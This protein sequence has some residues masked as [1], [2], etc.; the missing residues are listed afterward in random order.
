MEHT[1]WIKQGAD[2]AFPDIVWSRPESRV[3]AGKLL[4]VGGNTHAFSAPAQAF[5]ESEA[6]GVGVVNVLLP[7]SLRK[8]VGSFI[9]EAEYAPHTPSGSFAREALE[10]MLRLSTCSDGVLLAGDVGRNSETAML[11][12]AFT[13][14]YQGLLTVTHDVADYFRELPLMVVDRPNTLLVLSL[15]QLQKYFIHTPTITPI[16][17]SMSAIQLAEAL[18]QYTSDHPVAI[19]VKHN[20]LIFVAYQGKVSTTKYTEKM[21]RTKYASRASVYWLQNPHKPFEAMT[22]SLL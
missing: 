18:H 22:T 4:I 16:T 2:P 6:A 11:L 8:T 7:D 19:M 21:W 5:N 13:Q 3:T 20:E 15:E 12:E 14:K 1:Y 17:Y 10:P 9:P